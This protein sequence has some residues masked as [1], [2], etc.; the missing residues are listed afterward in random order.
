[1]DEELSAAVREV[2]VRLY[3]EGLIYRGKYI[4]NWC[5]RCLTALSDL[6]V[7]HR[8]VAGHLYYVRYPLED[9]EGAL[10]VATTRPET[11][12]GDT[13]VAVNPRDPRYRHLVGKRVR[14]PLADRVVPLIA[15]DY[16]DTEF[17]TG[18]LKITP[19]HDPYDF[20][21]G[22][23]HGLDHISIFTED[24]HL[25]EAGGR[26]AGMDRFECR[27]AFVEGLRS[28]DYLEKIENYTHAV[29]HCYRCN[30]MV[31]PYLSD[32][33]F[34][35]IKPLAGPAME[36]VRNGSIRLIPPAWEKTY[37]EWMTNIRDWCIS[38]QIWWGHRIPAW[39]CGRCGHLT[40]STEDPAG[41]ES[42][43]TA[44]LEQ[45]TDV[46]D[47]WFSSGLWPFST[48]GWPAQTPELDRFYPT[49]CLV[50]GFDILFFWVARMIMLGI[51]FM[52]EV[53]FRD[54]YVHA[55]VRDFE[56]HKMSKSRG[57]VIDPLVMMEKYGTDA[58]RFTLTAFA[59]Q[60]RDV[61]LSEKRIEGYRH[62]CNK[63]WNAA[64]FVLA[65]L[66]DY[67]RPAPEHLAPDLADRWI[68]SRLQH[69]VGQVR[70]NLEEYRFN[71]VAQTLYH[72]FWHEFCDW[73]IELAKPRLQRGGKE[74]QT[75]QYVLTTVLEVSLRLLHPIMP[76]I[77]EELW[78]RL[79]HKE[80]ESIVIVPYPRTEEGW[81]D[82]VAERDM[83]YLMS[84]LTSVRAI[85]GEM[86]IL[87]SQRIEVLIRTDGPGEE[88]V[89]SN[90]EYLTRLARMASLQV[91]QALER[92]RLSA[93]AV[94]DGTE[95][96]V[97]LSGMVDF[98]AEERRLAKEVVKVREEMARV[99]RKLADP[100]FG[101]KAPAEVVEVH[102]ERRE[103]LAEKVG[104]L[105]ESWRRMGEFVREMKEDGATSEPGR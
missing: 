93:I 72:F 17:G 43:G 53:P 47:T 73:H 2:F 70:K 80:A 100:E 67:S 55:L 5:P 59:A 63:V 32:Q 3:R 1:M 20:E 105:T 10:L 18:V 60:G 26:Y 89:R 97:P 75:A 6:E 87:P 90:Q 86:G 23:R 30:T 11:M 54:V 46:L 51:K 94:V 31:E 15:D 91:S 85:R 4:V 49:S 50:T 14:I 62:F 71:D 52:G 98:R 77:T 74:R 42:C 64:R 58:F 61:K 8:D 44:E 69:V 81:L 95:V 65:N 101:E 36:A 35:R 7:E 9:E 38:R 102:R 66:E 21:V 78:Q 45:E 34:V 76:F 33:W 27:R 104:K 79:P 92:P 88:L 82:A 48:P 28:G 96:Y 83:E 24:G 84:I 25:N 40:V 22:R 57:N 99:D 12:L 56:G 13:A 68:M 41:C 37:F 19:A 29:G 39:H 103:A 16:V